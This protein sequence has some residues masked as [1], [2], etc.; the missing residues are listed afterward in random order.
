MNTYYYNLSILR[1]YAVFTL[2]AWHSYCSYISWGIIDSPA[3]M[4]YAV[5][6]SIFA[7]A[8]NMPLFTFLSGYLFFLLLKG[9]GK[10]QVFLPF[11]WNKVNRLLIPFIILGS[12]IS[13]CEYG[14]NYAD[15]LYG[16]PNHLW[17]CIML[18]CCFIIS[19]L[20]EKYCYKVNY[21]LFVIS[22]C[23]ALYEG[24]KYL[25]LDSIMGWKN[26]LYF[27]NFFIAGLYVFKFGIINKVEN[28]FRKHTK[29]LLL[30]CII[31]IMTSLASNKIP[32]LTPITSYMLILLL[33]CFIDVIVLERNLLCFSGEQ[34]HSII[35]SISKYSF[36]VY[37]FHQW[38]IWNLTRIPE[39]IN[40]LKPYMTEHYIIFPFL[41]FVF[42]FIISYELTRICVK[43]K[44]GKYLLL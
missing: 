26:V 39:S 43:T 40:Y 14:K 24:D 41:F 23:Y 32:N 5:A 17:Y 10:Y 4:F 42:I 1:T 15:M 6:F 16:T 35:N 13:L 8:A 9:Q 25:C 19:W 29:L 30:A 38:F 7:P 37:V 33:F 44:I 28:L 2:V 11:L 31:Y 34:A 22:A 21:L 20:V 36:G 3:Q 27:Y 12:L 18:F